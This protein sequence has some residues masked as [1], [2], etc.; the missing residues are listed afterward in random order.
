L[1]LCL[2]SFDTASAQ[3]NECGLK[4][5]LL[6]VPRKNIF[7]EQQEQWLG[8]AQADRVE[9]RYLLLPEEQSKYLTGIG[10]KLLAQ[11]P[12]TQVQYRFQVFESSDVE[13]LSL[14]GGR[15]YVSRKLILDA[16]SD[17][18]LA[19]ALAHEIGRV[20]SHHAASVYTL[21]LDKLMGIKSLAGQ[22]DVFDQFQR[23]FNIPRDILQFKWKP[24][25]SI[26]D[27]E[28]DELL[29]DKVGFYV[30]VKAGYAPEAY[31]SIFDRASLN[32]GYKGNLFTDALELTLNISMRVRQTQKLAATLPEGCRYAQPRHSSEFKAFQDAMLH[33]RV[34]P[35]LPATPGLNYT[36]LTPSMSPA[37]ENVRLSP[38]ANYVLAQDEMQIHVLRREPPKLLFSIDAPG[39][40]M[41]QFSPDSKNVVFYYPGLRFETWNV[42][43]GQPIGALDFADYAGCLQDSLSP[44]GNTFACFSRNYPG[45]GLRLSGGGSYGW[46]K[47]SDLRTG[48]MLYENENFYLINF[49]AQ[50]ASVAQRAIVEPR[51]AS[52]AWSQDGRYFLAASGTAA[53]GFDLKEGKTVG[54]GNDLSHLYE[55]RMAFVD[56]DKLAFEC[57]WGH[58]EGGPRDTFKMCL[59]TFPDGIPLHTFTMGRTWMS[60]VTRGPRLV[61]GPAGA[62][63]AT[64]FDPASRTEGPSF[65]LDPVDL[66]GGIVAAEAE[67]GGVS[68]GPLGGM[69]Q[70]LPLPA[71]PLPSLEAAVFSADGRYLAIS[72]RARGAVWDL[73]SGKQISLT[74]PF[75]N[76]QFD[77]QG[78][79]QARVA[80]RE[81]KP[82]RDPRIDRRTGKVT[83]TIGIATEDIQYGSVVVRYKPLEADQELYFNVAIEAV[84]ATSGNP[85]WSRRFPNNPPMLQDTYCDQ[86]L[87]LMDRRSLTGGAELDHN[88]KLVVRTSDEFKE[89]DE[90]G[91]VV[92]VISRRTGIPERLVVAPETSSGR[93]FERTAS[94]FG[95]LLAI[96]GDS[97]TTV[98]YRLSDGARL[99][100]V[101]GRAIAGDV[102]L[103][104]IAATNR[105]QEVTIYEVATG[106]QVQRVTLD[107]EVL[108]ARIIPEK[109]Q[110]LVLTAT[111]RVYALDLPAVERSRQDRVH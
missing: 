54:M 109:K 1:F 91:L 19:G 15:I 100:A 9:P 106:K 101:F 41:A 94:L 105:P 6:A 110:L 98:V 11:L 72:D 13:A 18:E 66:A 92:E 43:T 30:Y 85:L 3:P 21:A 111:Q 7:S 77:S 52:V 24:Q 45:R 73:S 5:P 23:M 76:V 50:A 67:R 69:M 33:Q 63:A 65:K 102:G 83:P 90:R 27:Q 78:N 95:D 48:K 36:K 25:L 57:D 38:D 53:V 37:L 34:N 75:R 39:A 81:L 8:D 71:T 80:G 84:D 60:R 99:L 82:A 79:L 51:Q 35:L 20:Y 74:G 56:S 86:L 40:Q 14:A 29:A 26:E 2:S 68:T 22:A 12:P 88:K 47:L 55:S 46:L 17:D 103:G 97:N 58:K 93:G 61:T 107:N 16:R 104:L 4:Q 108:A 31:A 28:N 96:R 32:E 70:T 64:L 62:A 87:L 10:Q 89:L 44:D 42:A 59:T 49:A